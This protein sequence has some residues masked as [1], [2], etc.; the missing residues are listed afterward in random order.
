[1]LSMTLAVWGFLIRSF[2]NLVR[3]NSFTNLSMAVMARCL[4]KKPV[5]EVA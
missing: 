4:V 1:M 5:W 3:G 2:S